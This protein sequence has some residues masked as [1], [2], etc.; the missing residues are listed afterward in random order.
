MH[1]VCRILDPFL[2]AQAHYDLQYLIAS[3][4]SAP[5]PSPCS[6]PSRPGH[7][8][9]FRR[10]CTARG[11]LSW[12]LDSYGCHLSYIDA[13][14]HIWIPTDPCGS[15]YGWGGKAR[16]WDGR[17]RMRE[18]HGGHH[19]PPPPSP[20]TIHPSILLTA[21]AVTAPTHHH[22]RDHLLCNSFPFFPGPSNRTKKKRAG[23]PE[24]TNKSK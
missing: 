21:Q 14:S 17:G 4:P 9:P 1:E 10:R 23:A 16:D 8:G 5:L 20:P 11:G 18:N 15:R 2:P 3:L 6:A 12:G 22:R 24:G 7:L 13:P 19:P